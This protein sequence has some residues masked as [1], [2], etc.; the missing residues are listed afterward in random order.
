MT[1]LTTDRKTK[2][3][4][5]IELEYKVAGSAKIYAGALV[6]LNASGYAVPGTDTANFKFVGVAREQAD[7]S[8]GAN[9]DITVRVRRK[10][11]F[12]FAA[13]A[14]AITDIG[15]AVNVSDDQTVAKTTTNSIA[16]G[17]IA[18]LISATEVGV[19]IDM[20]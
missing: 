18:E 19:D 17:R 10:G 4:E 5:G 6:C 15:A 9:G 14:M 8:L 12:R 1:A 7:N 2:Y 11:V 13:S 20:R 16:C 3:R